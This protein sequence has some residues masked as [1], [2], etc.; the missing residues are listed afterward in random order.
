MRATLLGLFFLLSSIAVVYE[1]LGQAVEAPGSALEAA[2]PEEAR[3]LYLPH[4][5]D[6]E[7][8]NP[9]QEMGSRKMYYHVTF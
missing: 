1:A 4:Q 9:W 2:V 8:F 7:F 6:G 5:R 3:D